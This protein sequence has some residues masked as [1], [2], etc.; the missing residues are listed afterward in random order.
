VGEKNDGFGLGLH[1]PG[2]FYKV[3]DIEACLLQDDTGNRILRQVKNY[4]RESGVPVYG[5]KS[6]KGFWRFLTLRYSRAYDE[7]LV[8]LVTSEEDEE[9]IIPLAEKLLNEIPNVTTVINNINTKKAAIALGEREIIITGKGYIRDKIGPYNFQISANS[10]FQTNT[11]GAGNLYDKVLEYAELDGSQIVLDL[12]CGTGTIPIFLSGKAQEV[13][14]ME[15]VESA[16]HDANKNCISNNAMN[17]R[18]ILGDIREKLS[19][20]GY[21]P[22][23]LVIDP[24]RAGIHKDILKGIMGIAANRIVYVSCNPSTMARDIK[25][26]SKKYEVNEIQP[27]DMFPHTYH[28]E[29]VARMTLR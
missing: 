7:W 2:T 10:F 24:P 15:I 18:F 14:G 11:S 26:L 28:I 6:H 5:L 29:A 22:D 17:C 21:K 23:V 19:D 12:Y 20:I 25:G 8:N 13:V 1:V 4:V 27:V 16:V 9:I 3:I